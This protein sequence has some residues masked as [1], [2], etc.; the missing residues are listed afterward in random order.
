MSRALQPHHRAIIPSPPPTELCARKHCGGA[1]QTRAQLTHSDIVRSS[2][3]KPVSGITGRAH[4]RVS[5][6]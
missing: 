2:P 5:R 1:L 6:K 4:S 3:Q